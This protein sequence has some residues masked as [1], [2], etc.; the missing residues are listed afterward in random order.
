MEREQRWRTDAACRGRDPEEF[1]PEPGQ[2]GAVQAAVAVCAACPVRNPCLA[3]A[4]AAGEGRGVWGGLTV[5][6]RKALR[7]RQRRGAA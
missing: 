2:S 4:L 6:E 7:R 1:H 3:Y 5:N